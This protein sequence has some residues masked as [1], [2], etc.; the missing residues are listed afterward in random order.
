MSDRP[1][2]IKPPAPAPRPTSAGSGRR[3]AAWLVAG[4]VFTVL[5]L[6]AGIAVAGSSIWAAV[7][8]SAPSSPRAAPQ[9]S[10]ETETETEH[11]RYPR[12]AEQLDLEV[13]V[14]D[15][16]IV[17][18]SPERVEIERTL[19][20]SGERPAIAET[21]SGDTLRIVVDCPGGGPQRGAECKVDQVVQAPPEA[22]AAVDTAAGAIDVRDIH[23]ELSLS[24]AAGAITLAG[25]S[26][27]LSVSSAAGNI[28]GSDLRSPRV[29]A[30]L[31]AG[32][33]NLRFAAAPEHVTVEATAGSV[34]IEV[35]PGDAYQVRITTTVGAQQVDV[36]Q[37]PDADRVIEV[38]TT[39]GEVRI[40]YAA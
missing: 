6:L 26:G 29:E 14:G 7:P 24:T 28:T 8:L 19:R 25:V 39:V 36:V 18:G 22:G 34:T 12:A 10:T 23:G 21:W 30:R 2:P 13:P 3:R 9:S 15:V 31:Q 27:S 33:A 11:Q 40:R 20:W 4:G 5:A 37:D 35:P 38:R 16:S 17:A 1:V 32:T